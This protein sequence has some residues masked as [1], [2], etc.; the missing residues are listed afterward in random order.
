MTFAWAFL[1]P[2]LFVVPIVLGVYL[3]SLRLKRKQAVTYSSVALL[4]SVI[5][6]RSRW[7]RHV[8]AALLLAAL[9]VLAIASAR[10]QRTSNV[11]IA[12]TTIILA[13]DVSRSMCATDVDPNRLTVAQKAAKDFVNNQPTGTRMGLIIFAGT[14]QLGVAPTRDRGQLRQAIDNLSTGN[15]TAIGTA[16]LKSLDALS[17]VNK[18]VQPVGDVP[19]QSGTQGNDFFNP[20]SGG[21]ADVAPTPTTTPAPPGQ[22]GYVPDIVVLLTDGA[23][24]R[25]ISPLDAVPYAVDRRVRVYTIGFGTTEIAPLACTSAQLGGDESAFGGAFGPGGGFAGGFGG[26]GFSING[27]SPL[28]ADLPTLQQ[29]AD[30]TGGKAYAAQDADQ[31]QKVFSGLPRDVTVSKQKHEITSTFAVIGALLALAAV[32]ASIRWSP[33]P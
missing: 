18:D 30:R 7:R 6:A 26:G 13:L 23:N 22:H 27:R 33:Y 20:F 15:G 5:P 17:T 14:A 21:S 11:P 25:G 4:K 3:W 29:V 2:L 9:G 19:S 31:L 8:P 16:M 32:A 24:N 1:L 28:R 12:R 10:P